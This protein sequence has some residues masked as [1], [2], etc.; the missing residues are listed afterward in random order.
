LPITTCR[1][2]ENRWK[3]IYPSVVTVLF[4]TGLEQK[5]KNYFEFD[6]ESTGFIAVHGHNWLT[7]FHDRLIPK[8]D[9]A[10]KTT[11]KIGGNYNPDFTKEALECLDTKQPSVRLQAAVQAMGS[12]TAV[13]SDLCLL[14]FQPCLY[15]SGPGTKSTI[16]V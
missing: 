1:I 15:L 12:E 16:A 8:D 13:S 6:L 14:P 9:G 5:G 7:T 3:A 2:Y 4:V 10:L 11:F